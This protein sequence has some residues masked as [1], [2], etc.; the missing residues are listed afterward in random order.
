MRTIALLFAAC[1]LAGCVR[2]QTDPATGKIDV[3]VESPAQKGEHWKGNM[4]GMSAYMNMKGDA[5]VRVV[6]G[7]STATLKLRGGMSGQTHPWHVHEGKC[8][9][10]GPIVGDPMAYSPITIGSDGM[11]TS[12]ATFQKRL[13]E[14]TDYHVN[15]HQSSANLATI[16]ACGDIED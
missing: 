15:V 3:D 14:A 13:N 10:G 7:V 16:I 4:N 5:E 12:S 8:G 6:E 2:T 9:S 11:G 1:T